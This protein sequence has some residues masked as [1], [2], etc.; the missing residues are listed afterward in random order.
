MITKVK[1]LWFTIHYYCSI[2][3]VALDNNNWHHC[4]RFSLRYLSLG[5]RRWHFVLCRN[6][7]IVFEQNLLYNFNRTCRLCATAVDGDGD[8]NVGDVGERNRIFEKRDRN[9]D[10]STLLGSQYRKS[11]ADLVVLILENKM[12]IEVEHIWNRINY[13]FVL[14]LRRKISDWHEHCQTQR[15][16]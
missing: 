11:T 7:V 8:R 2:N 15:S 1:L 6:F 4:Y 14:I 12:T 5:R 9:M 3:I 10:R 16:S 13:W